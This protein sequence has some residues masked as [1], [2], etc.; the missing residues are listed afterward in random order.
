MVRTS[1]Y[2]LIRSGGPEYVFCLKLECNSIALVGILSGL[3]S[4]FLSHRRTMEQNEMAYALELI[5]DLTLF[6][7]DL[8]T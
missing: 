2:V 4:D 5:I 7:T 3:R 6:L 1:P 8:V